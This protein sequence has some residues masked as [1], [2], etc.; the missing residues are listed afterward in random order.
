MR[1]G[2]I[3]PNTNRQPN[4]V[5][6]LMKLRYFILHM[7]L[8]HK[9]HLYKPKQ[10]CIDGGNY[11][12]SDYVYM[13][14]QKSLGSSF[15][16]HFSPRSIEHTVETEHCGK[17]VTIPCIK[18]VQL[19]NIIKEDTNMLQDWKM[20][21]KNVIDT[22]KTDL[23]Y[24]ES[25]KTPSL[26]STRNNKYNL[27]YTPQLLEGI[28]EAIRIY[29]ARKYTRD[30]LNGLLSSNCT[31]QLDT[32]KYEK[33]YQTIVS[34]LVSGKNLEFQE[35]DFS[36]IS[37]VTSFFYS[38]E[39]NLPS[40]NASL[41][42]GRNIL[43][44]IMGQIAAIE[45]KTQLNKTKIA[46]LIGQ[47][48]VLKK[49]RQTVDKRINGMQKRMMVLSEIRAKND[50]EIS[51]LQSEI[52][53]LKRIQ[54]NLKLEMQ[55]IIKEKDLS[56]VEK[57][58]RINELNN[59]KKDLSQENFELKK[60]I[61]ILKNNKMRIEEQN[62]EFQKDLKNAKKEL[63]STE[64]QLTNISSKLTNLHINVDKSGLKNIEALSTE[65]LENLD[66]DFEELPK[67]REYKNKKSIFSKFK[68]PSPSKSKK[69]KKPSKP[70]K[71][72][73]DDLLLFDDDDDDNTLNDDE[74]PEVFEESLMNKSPIKIKSVRKR[75]GRP[76]GSKNKPRAKT[77][78]NLK[79]GVNRKKAKSKT[80]KGNKGDEFVFNFSLRDLM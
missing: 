1:G 45:M 74:L 39:P 53:K 66:K 31:I 38:E 42:K 19:N 40:D 50:A 16:S 6:D 79:I 37:D 60:N 29:K 61:G 10:R 20:L 65:E 15:Y 55:E 12:H 25:L 59:A 69:S 23:K 80:V 33:D 13:R 32:G 44:K 18:L 36:Y 22:K 62:R 34:R 48:G 9:A 71:E 14:Y 11:L 58:K 47:Y 77:T 41:M 35:P 52:G 17:I 2:N 76:K 4:K 68:K 70:R 24:Q 78:K 67:L 21:V 3:K 73:V 30:E 64:S 63:N 26:S 43:R 57:N 8:K 49:I 56:V 72:R 28:E 7:R 51:N 46:T 75:R 27:D 5:E 54:Q